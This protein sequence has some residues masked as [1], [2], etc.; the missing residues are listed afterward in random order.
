MCFQTLYAV[1]ICPSKKFIFHFYTKNSNRVT[2]VADSIGQFTIQHNKEIKKQKCAGWEHHKKNQKTLTHTLH[3]I[4]NT[5]LVLV[6]NVLYKVS[7]I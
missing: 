1:H 3:E 6:S 2:E 5:A 4:N 7:L